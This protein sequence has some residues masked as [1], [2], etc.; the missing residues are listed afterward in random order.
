MRLRFDA[1]SDGEHKEFAAARDELLD[2]FAVWLSSNRPP[3]DGAAV[4]HARL[5]LDWR[6][7]YS[8]GV[9]DE[10]DDAHLAEFLLEWCPRKYSAPPEHSFQVC[11][12]VG[13]LVEFL[14]QSNRLVGGVDRAARLITVAEDLGPEMYAAMGDRSRF[15]MAKSLFGDRLADVLG[16]DADVSPEELQA[17]LDAEMQGFNSLPFEE[18]RALTDRFFTAPVP[19]PMEL[20]FVHVPPPPGEVEAAAAASPIIAKFADLRDYLGDDGKPLTDR[21]NLKL[22]DGRAL[23]ELLGTGDRVDAW[24]RDRQFKTR[25]TEQLRNLLFLVEAAKLAGAVRVVRRTL[26]PVKAWALRP[27]VERAVAAYRAVIELGPLWTLHRAAYPDEV[28]NLLDEGIVHWLVMLL[29]RGAEALHDSIVAMALEVVEAEVPPRPPYWTEESVRR[30]TERGVSQIFEKLDLAGVVE[31]SGREQ[32]EGEWGFT[33]AA[34]GTIRLTALGRYALPEQ[35]PGA[36]YRLRSV[37]DLATA[38]AEALIEKIDWVSDDDRKALVAAWQPTRTPNERAELVA[39]AI[40]TAADSRTRLRGFVAI[41]LIG[42]DAA[43][44]H[45]R[46]LLDSPAAGN[47]ALFLIRHGLATDEDVGMFINIG[48]FVDLLATS[49]DDPDQLCELFSRVRQTGQPLQILQDMWR[50]PAPETAAVLDTL[51]RGLADRAL[52][53]A[54]RKAAIQHRSWMANRR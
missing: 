1:S 4:G 39:A 53:K 44:P 32:I 35:L 31:W 48:T 9:L 50:H 24:I 38:D 30:T 10:Y 7:D 14:S 47:A 54:A 26:V 29:P 12:A 37:G 33:R 22:A 25:S 28:D 46:Q 3:D 23:V 17:V 8:T 11:A 52:A 34:R 49:L 5:F 21:G 36:N 16:P 2:E 43:E 41:D 40:A 15:G 18:R 42:A 13:A 20:P 27:V 6:F 19:K 51:G 45:V